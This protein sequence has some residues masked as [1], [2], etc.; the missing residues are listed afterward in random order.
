M[1][2]DH[3]L[4]VVQ[5]GQGLSRSRDSVQE[6]LRAAYAAKHARW[7]EGDDDDDDKTQPPSAGSYSYSVDYSYRNEN[8]HLLYNNS[9]NTRSS[10]HKHKILQNISLLLDYHFN[11]RYLST[12]M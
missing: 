3:P 11:L 10:N 4:T 2:R 6:D 12:L 5:V 9:N 7:E 1:E 8:G